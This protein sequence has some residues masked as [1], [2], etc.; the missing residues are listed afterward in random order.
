MVRVSSIWR[1]VV[2]ALKPYTSVGPALTLFTH[3][4]SVWPYKLGVWEIAPD[5][6]R[7]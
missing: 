3:G 2:K 1:Q 7:G 6:D 4:T 5:K